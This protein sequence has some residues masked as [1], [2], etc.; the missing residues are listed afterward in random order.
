[1]NGPTPSAAHRVMRHT[2][3]EDLAADASVPQHII[4][5]VL[6]F[7]SQLVEECARE[8]SAVAI[9]AAALAQRAAREEH[10]A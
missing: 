4:D 2:S 7:A 6:E 5:E 10:H 1:M 3:L 8:R 9:T